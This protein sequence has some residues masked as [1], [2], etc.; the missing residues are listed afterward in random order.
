MSAHLA[1]GVVTDEDYVE[2][3]VVIRQ[4]SSG[5][6]GSWCAVSRNKL[7]EILN[8]KFRFARL[9][10]QEIVELWRFADARYARERNGCS[11]QRRR[12]RD[13]RQPGHGGA[14]YQPAK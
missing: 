14:Q 10:F 1:G 4:V 5:F 6:L 11:I 2:V 8:S 9:I 12:R 7:T 3:F 13:L